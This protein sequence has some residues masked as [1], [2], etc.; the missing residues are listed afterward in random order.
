MARLLKEEK[1]LGGVVGQLE[2][3][4]TFLERLWKYELIAGGV[5]AALGV[6]VGFLLGNWWTLG[7]GLFLAFLGFSHSM[8]R[9]DNTADIGRFKGGAEGEARVTEVMKSGLPDAYI[10][11]N[12]VTVRSG[13]RSAQN[14]HLV[15]GPNGV[16]V[17]ETKAYS[18]TLTGKASDEYLE[19]V[20]EWKG[21]KTEARIKNPI[22]QNEYHLRIVGEKMAEGG[23]AT[24]DL[25]SVIVFTNKWARLRI[26]DAAVPVVKP[27]M[28]VPTLL[29][30]KARYAYDEE[31]L[32]RLA[33]FLAP[34]IR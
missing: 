26:E 16:F 12:D 17:I 31:W 9:R 3:E 4:Q 30:H 25:V 29:N 5:I 2:R 7:A 8:K 24:D 10:I 34:E 13:V 23:F 1:T 32:M 21:K 28:L 20:K 11:L 18:G 33:R 15:L 19:Q 27:E 22:P 14:D 6:G